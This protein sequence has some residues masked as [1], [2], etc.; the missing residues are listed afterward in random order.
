MNYDDFENSPWLNPMFSNLFE[1]MFDS[2]FD[3]TYMKAN[4]PI[5]L[6]VD[7]DPITLDSI[8][9]IAFHISGSV[10]P[11]G[12]NLELNQQFVN[13]LTTK[14][15]TNSFDMVELD[16]NSEH[17]QDW[18]D[19]HA[20]LSLVKHWETFSSFSCDLISSVNDPNEIQQIKLFRSFPNPVL[21][22]GTIEFETK[23]RR[24]INLDIFD[25]LGNH[26]TSVLSSELNP[27]KH[28]IP[29]D[30]SSFPNGIYFYQLESDAKIYTKKLLVIR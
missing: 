17:N 24:H 30:V 27:G 19:Y 22:L 16:P 11:S 29:I 9:E 10:V 23:T 13:Y 12:S 1:P 4:S 25:S 14:G 20:T 8:K 26:L 21:S 7:A 6:L 28:Q 5:H 2:P 18:A 15:I 3:T